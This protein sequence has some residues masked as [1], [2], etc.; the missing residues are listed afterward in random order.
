MRVY[1][2][3]ILLL[4]AFAATGDAPG[5]DAPADL[6]WMVPNEGLKRPFKDQA[7]MV[8]VTRGQNR[9]AWEGLPKFWNDFVQEVVDPVT[10]AKVP[11]KVVLIKVPLGINMPVPV[12]AEN[13]M[14]VARWELGK[15]LFFDSILC[16]DLTVSCST[17]HSPKNGYTDGARFS[18]GISGKVGGMS[19]P[20]V[21]NSAFNRHHFW[22]GR[23]TSLEDQAQ[24]PPQ[25]S[26]EMFDGKGNAWHEVVNRVRAKPEYVKAFELEFGHA[27]TRDSIAKAIAAYERTVLVGNS[28]H[29]RAEVAMRKRVEDEEGNKFDILPKD[30]ETVLKQAFANKD[31]NG[32]KALNLDVAKDQV[33]VAELANIIDR[34]R[35]L[36]FNKARCSACHV[37]ESFT[38]L[39]F[40]NLGVGVKDGKLPEGDLGRFGSLPTGHKD[41]GQM[42]AFKT[43]QLRGLLSTKPYMHDGSEDTLEKVVDFYDKGGNAN[44]FLDPKMRDTDAEAKVIKSGMKPKEVTVWT[45]DGK[46]IIPLKLNLTVD[47]KKDLVLFLRTLESDPVDATVA[48]AKWFPK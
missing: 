18:T 47:E 12:P 34:G 21:L 17:C 28:I 40:H 3:P 32:L 9:K 38:D 39:A 23:A 46:P 29:D 8:F 22:D 14:T 36:F 37:G 11:R 2:W 13:P 4:T 19:A 33:K 25:N 42:G 7:S 27:P 24:G 35:V 6:D 26:I 16:S 48:D 41:H 30:Y 5:A 1:F 15:K 31:L 45:R 20:P 43:S 10:G 44:E